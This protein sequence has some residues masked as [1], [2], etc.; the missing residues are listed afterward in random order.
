MRTAVNKR[1]Q[2]GTA[3]TKSPWFDRGKSFY[4]TGTGRI[5]TDYKDALKAHGFKAAL[6]EDA[7]TQQGRLQ[8]LMLHETAVSWMRRRLARTVPAQAWAE[9][10]QEY[11][12][13][14]KACCDEI[15]A[16]LDVE[17]LCRD[18]PKRI[19]QLVK[20]EGGRLKE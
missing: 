2:N 16:D 18:F 20:N 6:G 19:C 17:G 14:L 11:T 7:N 1:F 5:T 4:N 10:R 15:N 12:S 9:T 8:E 3:Q 13:R